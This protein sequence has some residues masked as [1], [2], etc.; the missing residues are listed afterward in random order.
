ME[1]YERS[2]TYLIMG[3]Y[4]GCLARAID[5]ILDADALSPEPRLRQAF[6]QYLQEAVEAAPRQAGAR[7]DAAQQQE[8]SHWNQNFLSI[9]ARA[10]KAKQQ[11]RSDQN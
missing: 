6:L 5:R 7:F 1:D 3:E 11:R 10:A 9:L 2:S 8:F 4:L